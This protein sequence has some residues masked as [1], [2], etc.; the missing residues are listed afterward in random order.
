MGSLQRPQGLGVRRRGRDGGCR[1]V[2]VVLSEFSFKT[3]REFVGGAVEQR[4]AECQA[5]PDFG[6]VVLVIEEARDLLTVRDRNRGPWLLWIVL[7]AEQLRVR[8]L[9]RLL[10]A[11][12]YD[13]LIRDGDGARID[14]SRLF[15]PLDK[16]AA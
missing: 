10:A 16:G 15:G 2:R 12:K 1:S 14:G 8:P 5:E 11:L 3:R 6:R 4:D 13:A 7:H 9:P